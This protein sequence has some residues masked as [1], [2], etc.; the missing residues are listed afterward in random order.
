MTL[1][2]YR[3]ASRSQTP[4]STPQQPVALPVNHEGGGNAKKSFFFTDKTK[5]G[6]YFSTT[7]NGSSSSSHPDLAFTSLPAGHNKPKQLRAEAKE[8]VRSLQASR[9]SLENGVGGLGGAET[10]TKNGSNASG[11]G[12]R[13]KIRPFSPA[14]DRPQPNP[15]CL[16]ASAP[17]P[18][19]KHLVSANID[20]ISNSPVQSPTVESPMTPAG[21]HPDF[22]R[23][24]LQ[25]Y[26]ME[27]DDVDNDVDISLGVRH[28]QVMIFLK[29]DF[30]PFGQN[31]LLNLAKPSVGVEDPGKGIWASIKPSL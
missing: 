4:V 27:D 13:R 22:V 31:S 7:T 19:P 9:N 18:F 11:G 15:I 14:R 10:L 16:S 3:D 1:R 12:S 29:F 23:S 26:S 17:S 28:L 6:H 20:S 2:F 24:N 21:S 8:M 5:F 30:Y 25:Y